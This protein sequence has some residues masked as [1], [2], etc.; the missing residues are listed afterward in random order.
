MIGKRV[1]NARIVLRTVIA[2]VAFFLFWAPP[3]L[4]KTATES[5]VFTR[6]RITSTTGS[7]VQGITLDRDG[8]P[9]FA[10]GSGT[11]GKL[12]RHTGRLSLYNL[13]NPH[14]GVGYVRFDRHGNAWFQEYNV[15]A[16]G[17][18]NPVT[19]QDRSKAEVLFTTLSLFP[20]GCIRS[21]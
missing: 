8:N 18:I 11:I 4:A 5:A 1:R 10:T 15:P 19:G 21:Q 9:W 14:A 7:N 13:A 3:A 20:I 17:E 6:Y 16:I 2:I 12:N